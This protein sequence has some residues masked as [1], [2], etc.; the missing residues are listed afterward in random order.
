MNIFD[1]NRGLIDQHT[2]RECKAS[3]RHHVDGLARAPQ[4]YNRREQ[5]EGNGD[6]NDESAPP[7]SPKQQ[8]HQSRQSSAQ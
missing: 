7:I 2:D 4:S 3:Q 1:L 5:R 8:Y 6:D